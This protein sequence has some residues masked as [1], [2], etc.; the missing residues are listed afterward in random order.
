MF[1]YLALFQ[2]GSLDL[3]LTAPLHWPATSYRP[4]VR[5]KAE[6]PEV[7]LLLAGEGAHVELTERDLRV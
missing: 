4:R 7:T 3:L 2:W 6:G 1:P 5:E